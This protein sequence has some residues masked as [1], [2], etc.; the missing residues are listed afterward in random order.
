MNEVW[1]ARS[2]IVALGRARSS[3]VSAGRAWPP[4]RDSGWKRCL[5]RARRG[6]VFIRWHAR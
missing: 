4:A 2:G 6:A 5:T 3:P 1:H